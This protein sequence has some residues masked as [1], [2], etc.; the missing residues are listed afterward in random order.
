MKGPVKL[1]REAEDNF[2]VCLLI[3]RSIWGD[4]HTNATFFKDSNG[5]TFGIPHRRV[6]KRH[7]RAGWKN[8]IRSTGIVLFVVGAVIGL[9]VRFWVTAAL[10]LAMLGWTT[11]W[12]GRKGVRKSKRYWENKT[13]ITPMAKALS[14]IPQMA[15]DD[16]KA[17]VTM[18]PKWMEIERGELGRVGFPDAFHANDMERDAVDRLIEA[19]MPKPVEVKWHKAAPIYARIMTAPPLP[20]MISFQDRLAE[21][22]KCKR[23]EYVIGY[24]KDDKPLILSHNGDYPMKAF[25]MGS[26]TGKSATLRIIAAQIL[27]NDPRARLFV[28]DTKQVSLMSL[29]GINGVYI[30]SD[31]E[32]M[33]QM[34]NEWAWL[35][36]EMRTR[37]QEKRAG[38][39]DFDDLYVFMEEE[40]DFSVQIKNYYLREIRPDLPKPSPANPTIWAENIAPIMWQGREVRI[41]VVCV[42]QNLMD[43]YFGNMSLRPAFSTIGMAGF[44]PGAVRTIIQSP[45]E[46]PYQDGQGRICIFEG[47]RE[48]WI[49]APY[50]DEPW[51]RNYAM[52][53]EREACT[54]ERSPVESV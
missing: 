37:Y 42:A 51:L 44:K 39:T 45:P 30:Y 18:R 23:G 3:G 52:T 20:S 13:V 38:K 50:A 33:G 53:G 41:F 27:R 49:Q 36:Q 35:Y 48:T 21:I 40:N 34:W 6:T 11:Y 22:Q 12:Y 46:T 32:N 25:S 24:P 9:G 8:L 10:L 5:K 17:S 47:R 15:D 7:H 4:H 16:M 19:R 31:P 26:S 29:E 2:I 1:V 43:R 28:F 54:W 14:T